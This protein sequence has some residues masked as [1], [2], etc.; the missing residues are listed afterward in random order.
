SAAFTFYG[1]LYSPDPVV[2]DSINTLCDS[3]PPTDSIPTD[4]HIALQSPFTI[5][6]LLSGTLRTKLHSSPGVDG[7]P[8]AIINVIL[9]HAKAAKLAVKV[10][11]DA[12]TLGIFP[13]SWLK[14]C[15][16]LLPKSGDL[17]NL[18]NW[19]PLSLICCDAK[20][21]TRLLNSRLMPL[22]NKLICPQQS[23]FM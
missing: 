4:E 9:Q 13:A 7:L 8:Y 14:T 12:L 2:P 15:M 18:K 5:A 17:S 16:C 19:R 3:I 20:I 21:F 1:K 22:M 23:G 11:N 10:F 6:D